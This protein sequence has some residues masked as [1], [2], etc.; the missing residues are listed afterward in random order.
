MRIISVIEITNGDFQKV[1]SFPILEEQFSQDIIKN[2][3]KLFSDLI[4]EYCSQDPDKKDEI[5]YLVEQAIENG[6]YDSLGYTIYLIW[7][8]VNL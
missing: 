2:A 5:D 3:E 1:E 6:Y 4:E 8:N 7:S